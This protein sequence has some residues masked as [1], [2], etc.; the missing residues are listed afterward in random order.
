MGPA[1]VLELSRTVC[2]A[3]IPRRWPREVF[4]VIYSNACS[5][6]HHACRINFSSSS[7]KSGCKT[8]K[9]FYEYNKEYIGDRPLSLQIWKDEPAEII[10]QIR[11]IHAIDSKIHVK[12]PIVNTS[13][14]YNE[15]AIRYAVNNRIPVNI[16]ALHT[17][18]QINKTKELLKDS[19]APEIISVFAGPISDVLIVPDT[20]IAHALDCFKGKANSKIL[21]AGCRELYTIKRAEMLGCHI[22]TIPDAMMERLPLLS[23]SLEELTLDRVKIFKGDAEK[24]G[25]T[26]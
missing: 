2:E 16:T 12:I 13:G 19:V 9:E 18:E 22:I 20:Y 4:V 24:G 7:I 11:D 21:W 23:K 6:C 25:Y 15:I 1:A 8:Y 17:V 3:A 10:E 26:V 5:S 14:E